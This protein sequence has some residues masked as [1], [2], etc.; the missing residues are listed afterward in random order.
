MCATPLTRRL[1]EKANR[2]EN[3]VNGGGQNAKSGKILSP[4]TKLMEGDGVAV[5]NEKV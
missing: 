3:I 1:L 2:I 4:A 5:K